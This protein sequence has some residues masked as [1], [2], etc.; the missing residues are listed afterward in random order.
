MAAGREGEGAGD[1]G[2][3]RRHVCSRGTV[4]HTLRHVPAARRGLCMRP[5]L[6]GPGRCGGMPP[7]LFEV[8]KG[9]RAQ[10]FPSPASF[11]PV[12]FWVLCAFSSSSCHGLYPSA[13][14]WASRFLS[15][16]PGLPSLRTHAGGLPGPASR[17][18]CSDPWYLAPGSALVS[19]CPGL[20]LLGAG[21]RA[22]RLRRTRSQK[23][24]QG[25]GWCPQMGAQLT[26]PRR[27]WS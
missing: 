12:D 5:A 24:P 3:G 13:W 27:S 25:A 1:K 6:L 11:L 21:R 14:T 26:Q 7:P 16:E 18:L 15:P 9:S 20:C 22:P 4:S 19:A 23:S 8:R 10:G 2:E 17:P